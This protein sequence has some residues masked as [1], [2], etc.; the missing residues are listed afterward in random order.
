MAGRYDGQPSEFG[1]GSGD[2]RTTPTGRR[3]PATAGQQAQ[4]IR[5]AMAQER[6]GQPSDYREDG[7]QV[8]RRRHE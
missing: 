7:R 2:N 4:D 8:D 3:L 5:R 6:I 1:G